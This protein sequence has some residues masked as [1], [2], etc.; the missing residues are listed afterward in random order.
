[1]VK[2]II[3]KIS[4]GLGNQMFAY[5]NGLAISKKFNYDI[6]LDNKSAY[7]KKKNIRQY[8]LDIFKITTK[9]ASNKYIYNSFKKDLIKKI[10]L[11]LD[12]FKL[13][14]NFYIEKKQKN[15]TAF[16]EDINLENF[17]N[18]IY[19]EGHFESEHYF[20]DIKKILIE[21]FQLKKRYDYNNYS[22]FI[23]ENKKKIVALTLR[24]NRFSERT[25]NRNS[26]EAK[27][28]S[29]SFV[30]SQLNYINRS[31]EYFKSKIE[32]PLFLIFSNL[33]SNLENFFRK[34]DQFLKIINTDV[35]NEYKTEIDYNLL[36]MCQHHIVG[37]ST[38]HW[39]PA[40]LN[41][42]NSK[43]NLVVRPT[44]LNPSN[45]KDFWPSDWYKI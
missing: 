24:Q 32:N 30:R 27:I 10:L 28:K 37:P 41:Y 34:E 43:D 12:K 22:S 6:L 36:S 5:S 7:F 18:N 26:V 14:K 19:I 38:F 29:E 44:D 11:K 9:I 40:W 20:K 45:N 2:K 8:N 31:M 25:G 13:N 35:C 33:S 3:I 39:W 4:E 15:K 21:E 17:N 42:R 1:M 23:E 16:Y